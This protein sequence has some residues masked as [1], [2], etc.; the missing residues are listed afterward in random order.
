MSLTGSIEEKV[1]LPGE[2]RFQEVAAVD[3][4]I[5]VQQTSC[6][7]TTINYVTNDPQKWSSSS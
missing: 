2:T 1:F 4:E 7:T 3:K 6:T 5:A